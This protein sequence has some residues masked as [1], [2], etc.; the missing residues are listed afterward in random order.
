[1]ARSKKGLGGFRPESFAPRE[2]R[3]E[4]SPP[5]P[6]SSR[7]VDPALIGAAAQVIGW[8]VGH[9]RESARQSR[10]LEA[11]LLRLAQVRLGILTVNDAVRELGAARAGIEKQLAALT[12]RGCCR[13][14]IS[15]SGQ[16]IFVFDEFLPRL[17][18]C[19]HC[20]GEWAEERP[21]CPGC[22]APLHERVCS[23]PMR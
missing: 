11:G 10:E 9:W 16:E 1:M 18:A 4:E 15:R 2:R 5:P 23:P 3:S 14:G 17:Y 19:H 12:H 20:D 6:P 22:G 7:S 21:S 13:H 8:G